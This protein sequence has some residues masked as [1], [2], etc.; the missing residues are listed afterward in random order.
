MILNPDKISLPLPF[1][2]IIKS[3][4]SYCSLVWMFYLKKSNSIV[5]YVHERV[6]RVVY[7]DHSNRSATHPHKI[8]ILIKDVYVR[9]RSISSFNRWHVPSR[10]N[11]FNFFLWLRFQVIFSLRVTMIIMRLRVGMSLLREHKFKH[12]FQACLSPIC[13]CGLDIESTSHFSSPL[14]YI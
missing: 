1:N 14:S 8:N 7:D 10:E 11:T 2:I 13:S 3:Q 4:F 12:N 9:K 5:N 6:L